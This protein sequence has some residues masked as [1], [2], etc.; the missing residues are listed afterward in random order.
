MNL[1]NYGY[2]DQIISK[3]H[4]FLQIGVQTGTLSLILFI[5][6]FMYYFKT[7]IKLYIRGRFDSYYSRV[8]VAILI[9]TIS[10]MIA[11]LANDSSITVAPLFWVLIGLG[12]VVNEKA[13]ENL[14]IE[15]SD[16]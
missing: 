5:A 11:G 7:S 3:L 8:G 15:A 10:Y 12:I 6:F 16:N 13:K 2:G 4:I 1:N 14:T 9:S